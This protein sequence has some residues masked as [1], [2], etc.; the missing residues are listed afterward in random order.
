MRQTPLVTGSTRSTGWG[1][2][3]E[4][5]LDHFGLER[6]G[7]YRRA[8][9]SVTEVMI[10]RDQE[11]GERTVFYRVYIRYTGKYIINI[12]TRHDLSVR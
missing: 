11:G 1:G 9:P 4:V 8:W 3:L 10:S 7:A 12:Y 5:R 2:A 6:W